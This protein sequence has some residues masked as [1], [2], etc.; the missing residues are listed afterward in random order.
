MLSFWLISSYSNFFVCKLKTGS[1]VSFIIR[2]KMVTLFGYQQIQL[3][4][5]F[6]E[7]CMFFVVVTDGS[8]EAVWFNSVAY[9]G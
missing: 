2:R 5:R 8:F 3:K 6:F 7:Q 9:G 4:V 1:E